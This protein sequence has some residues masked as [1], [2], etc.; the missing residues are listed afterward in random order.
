MVR[1]SP[2]PGRALVPATVGASLRLPNLRD[3]LGT[4]VLGALSIR[5]VLAGHRPD[6]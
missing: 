4:G 6:A 2:V 1:A 5:G 3:L